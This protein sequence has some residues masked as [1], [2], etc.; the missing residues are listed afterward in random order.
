[1]WAHCGP[2]SLAKKGAPVPIRDLLGA[3]GAP[4]D[5]AG[6]CVAILR[7][8]RAS[9]NWLRWIA[10]LEASDTGAALVVAGQTIPVLS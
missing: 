1:M 8:V 7:M 3:T 10:F 2:D 6:D 5:D 9:S 4:G